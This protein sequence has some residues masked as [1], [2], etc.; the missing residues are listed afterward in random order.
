[1]EQK[2][3]QSIFDQ[4]T[5]FVIAEHLFGQNEAKIETNH[6]WLVEFT[7]TSGKNQQFYVKALTKQD[8]LEKAEGL[9]FMAM[10]EFRTDK[11]LL[12]H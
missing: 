9:K 4:F 3:K 7:L 8:A 10:P 6:Y 11:L 12:K 1:M 5:G 2:S